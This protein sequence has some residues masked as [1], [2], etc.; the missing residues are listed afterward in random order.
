MG[1]GLVAHG[2]VSVMAGKSVFDDP[3]YMPVADISD[4]TYDFPSSLDKVPQKSLSGATASKQAGKQQQNCHSDPSHLILSESGDYSTVDDFLE[5]GQNADSG[6]SPWDTDFEGDE[7]EEQDGEH[8]REGG[9]RRVGERHRVRVRQSHTNTNGGKLEGSD[10]IYVDGNLIELKPMVSFKS[11]VRARSKLELEEDGIYQGLVTTDEQK[12]QIGIMPESIYMT[13]A[14][15][16]CRDELENM[17]L[18][19]DE[20]PTKPGIYLYT[21]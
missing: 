21:Y 12:Q 2:D 10:K 19:I 14:L 6:D 16:T 1:A 4:E 5:D 9:G 7:E 8:E 11:R 3:Q 20:P 15:E 13:V 17:S 18:V